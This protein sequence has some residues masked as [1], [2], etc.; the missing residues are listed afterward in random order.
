[1]QIVEGKTGRF[2][3]LVRFL[4]GFQL[5]AKA[6]SEEVSKQ[7][8]EVKIEGVDLE[9]GPFCIPFKITAAG[10][11]D[12]LSVAHLSLYFS[13]FSFTCYI[14]HAPLEMDHV[15]S[16]LLRFLMFT[17]L[18][19]GA[20]ISLRRSESLRVTEGASLCI[21]VNKILISQQVSFVEV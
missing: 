2:E 8:L 17:L 10:Y 3:N 21:A 1:M 16:R 11:T 20:G 14:M 4:P 7:R 13:L 6:Q 12:L 9:V 18:D 19:V 15:W 5:R